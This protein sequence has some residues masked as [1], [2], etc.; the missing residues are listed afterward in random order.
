VA[1]AEPP[2]SAGMPM[3]SRSL[4]ASSMERSMVRGVW[5]AWCVLICATGRS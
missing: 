5:C 3:D 1:E 2:G 4:L